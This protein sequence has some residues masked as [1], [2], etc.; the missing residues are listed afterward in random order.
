VLKG[1]NA[2]LN[3]I[4]YLPTASLSVQP[5]LGFVIPIHPVVALPVVDGNAYAIFALRI[6]RLGYLVI[7]FFWVKYSLLVGRG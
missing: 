1:Y 3:S 6:C 5:H 4:S 7:P 2:P